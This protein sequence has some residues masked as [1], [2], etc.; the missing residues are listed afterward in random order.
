[1][2]DISALPPQRPRFDPTINLGHMITL[3]GVVITIIGGWYAFDARLAAVERQM[4]NLSTV[5]VEAARIDER[6]KGY[7]RRLDRVEAR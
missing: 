3:S 5:V 4:S 7:E 1:M 2:V 6:L